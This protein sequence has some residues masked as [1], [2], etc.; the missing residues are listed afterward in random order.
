MAWWWRN[1]SYL[2]GGGGGKGLYPGRF[3]RDEIRSLFHE[4]LWFE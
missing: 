1:A 3:E 4:G 2:I